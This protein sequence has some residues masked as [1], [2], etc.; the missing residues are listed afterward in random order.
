MSNVSDD[1]LSIILSY[2]NDKT[3]RN[4][5]SLVCK[6]WLRV[7][8]LNRLSIRVHELDHL[9]NFLPRFP[10]LLSFVSPIVITDAHLEFVAKTCL[11]IETLNL[12]LRQK[13]STELVDEI[14]LVDVG[15]AGIRAIANGCANLCKVSL[16][17]RRNIGN[18][19]VLSIV[20]NLAENLIHLNIGWC[21]LVDDV[22]MEAIGKLRSILV[23][24]LE[25]CSL[26]TD[27]GLAFLAKGLCSRSLKKLFIG[28]C[29]RITDSGVCLLDQMCS[30]EELSL[31]DCGPNVTD[32]GGVAVASIRTLRRLVL[33][34]LIN[35][36]DVT[37]SAIAANCKDLVALD[38]TGCGMITGLGLHGFSNHEHLESL[39]LTS[40]H[41]ISE[42]DLRVVLQCQSLRDI[43]RDNGRLRR[44]IPGQL[45]NF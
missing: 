14:G 20:D 43:V 2:I 42:G 10:N 11:K 29:D 45:N 26:I 39:V 35:V 28:D 38:L 8:G 18:L 24:N 25:G 44:L 41:N 40:C 36:S 3:D 6:Q 12:S 34:W 16:R 7:D 37:L 27:K 15:D 13:T 30:L 21:S 19:G 1:E 4:S 17:R 33:S 31:A 5:F 32:I 9:Q 22:G 23:L